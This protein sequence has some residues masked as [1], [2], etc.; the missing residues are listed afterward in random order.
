MQITKRIIFSWARNL[1]PIQRSLTGNGNR[2][3]LRY[4]KKKLKKLKIIEIKSGT[5]V[6]DWKI[7][8]EWNIKDA[9]IKNEKNLKVVDYRKNNLHVLGYSTPVNK[10]VSV[11]ELKRNL[12][13]IK[14]QPNAIPYVTSYY[15]KRWGFCLSFNDF[16]KLDSKKY[17]VVIKSS[18]KKGSMSYGELYIKGKTKKEVLISTNICH[19]SMANN[20]VSGM[21]VVMAIA[22]FL[23]QKKNHYSYRLIFIPE[24]IG[25]INYISKN[26]KNLKTNLK[27]GFVLTCLGN[28]KHFSIVKNIKT[29]FAERTVVKVLNNNSLSYKIYPWL[30]RGSD[31]RQFC[32]PN[33]DLPVVCISRSKFHQFKEYHTSL[34]NLNF[35]T[36]K[37]LIDSFKMLKKC[38]C[39]IDDNIFYTNTYQCEPFL[40]KYNLMSTINKF[41]KKKHLERTKI[42]NILSYCNGENNLDDI[43]KYTKLS[44]EYVKKNLKILL[45]KKIIKRD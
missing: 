14:S 2:T 15:K 6:F 7:P 19:P 42:L 23:L 35:I 27:A 13:F 31:E 24:T 20:E 37:G 11:H 28:E 40:T 10:T 44:K 29:N 39:E 33:V 34:D 12:Y 21:V 9:Y 43:S 4:I 1:F 41:D 17:K 8:N 32:S 3:T 36:A 25:S 5:K 26:Y 22:K 38:I 45:N 30:D 18:L 16:K